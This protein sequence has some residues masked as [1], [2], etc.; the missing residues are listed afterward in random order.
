MKAVP[1]PSTLT[2]GVFF[3]SLLAALLLLAGAAASASEGTLWYG[4]PATKW[5]QEALPIGNGRLG[6]MIFG[7]MQKEHIQFNEETLWIGDEVDTGAY[8]AFGDVYLEFAHPDG[9]S[10]RREL[11]ISRGVHTITYASGGVHYRREYFAS[12]PAKVMVLHFTAD[13]PGAYSGTVALTD[14]HGGKITA[15]KNR[16][17][18][19]GSLAG[20]TYAKKTKKEHPKPSAPEPGYAITLQYEAQVV[21]LNDGGSLESADGKIALKG[22]NSLTIFLDAGTDFVQ[23]RR[24]GWRGESPHRA[25]TKR[26]D[27]AAKTPYEQLLSAHVN[28]FQGLF[29]RVTLDLGPADRATAALPTDQRMANYKNGVAGDT[30]LEALLFQYG[31]YLLISSSRPGGLPANLQG[32][33]NQSNRPPWRCDYHTDI[34]VQMNYWPAD[35]ANLSECFEPYARW[36]NSIREVRKEA[37]Q[38]QFNARGWTM[39]GENGLFGGSTWSWVLPSSAWCLQNIWDHYA[40]TSDKEYLRVLAYPMMREV[41]EFWLDTLQSLPDGTLV[42]PSGFSPE[43]G[44]KQGRSTQGVSF[45]QELVWDLFNN[46]VEAAD[47]LGADR[48][49]RDTLAAKRDKLLVPKIGKWGQLQEWMEDFDDPHDTHRHLSHLIALHPGRQISPLTTPKLAEAAKISLTAR[50]DGAT[51]WSKAW[52]INLWARL[53]EGDHAY[54]IVTEWIRGSVLPNLFDTCAPFQIDGNFGYTAGVCEMLLQSHAGEIQL[55]PALPKA[56]STGSV[57]G[58]RARGN[59]TVDIQWKDG[60]VTNYR[61]TSPDPRGVKIRVNG[62]VKTVQAEK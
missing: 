26:L 42:S 16:L 11:D 49:F 13:Q 43:H 20:Y 33:W 22:A 34:N 56:W 62:Q 29:G 45:D 60:Q 1:Q 24:T 58:L 5:E 17:A 41:C 15:E 14:M 47:V 50:G 4:T 38:K 54:K 9:T 46:T 25:I 7:G 21:V 52:K 18:S 35:E 32:K 23:D 37:T 3:P 8:Q 39:H 30:A 59:F 36:L 51:G 19:A 12:Y 2:Q 10:Y 31:R 53:L 40:F 48:E 44:P 27:A 61:I 28:D 55:L 57:K 6:A